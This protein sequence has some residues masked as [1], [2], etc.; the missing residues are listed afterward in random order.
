[1]S[2][3]WGVRKF[4]QLNTSVSVNV[5]AFDGKT[6]VYPIFATSH[7]DRCHHVNL[8]MLNEGEKRHYTWIRNMSRLLHRPGDCNGKKFYCNYCMHGF[9]YQQA[10][11]NHI[12]DCRLHGAQ[13]VVMPD[14]NNDTVEFNSMRKTLKAPFVIYADSSRTRQSCRV[15]ST[16]TRERTTTSST[17]RAALPTRWSAPRAY[18]HSS[19]WSSGAK[20]LLRSL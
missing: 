17:S 12:E 19:Q 20:M 7:R 14:D 9:S 15:R 8:L 11:D 1:M 3:P 2:V 16:R 18:T 10:F 4:E 5:F 13:K 6:G